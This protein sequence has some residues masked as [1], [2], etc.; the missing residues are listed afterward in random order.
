VSGRGEEERRSGKGWLW[1]F[2]L[3]GSVVIEFTDVGSRKLVGTQL[4]R[5]P[6]GAFLGWNPG[7]GLDGSQYIV[8]ALR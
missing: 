6:N 2:T 3:L 4:S 7:C 1:V 5:D 8:T